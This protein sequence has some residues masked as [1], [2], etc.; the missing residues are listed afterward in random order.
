MEHRMKIVLL[1]DDPMERALFTS[2]SRRFADTIAVTTVARPEK[3][4]SLLC[5]PD[6]RPDVLLLDQRLSQ[7]TGVSVF[8]SLKQRNF[9]L[10]VC[11][12]IYS[13]G[14]DPS[15][16]ETITA[17]GIAGWIEKPVDLDAYFALLQSLRGRATLAA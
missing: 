11:T 16:L 10:P 5:D 6:T 3:L 1:D 7:H 8:A 17:L 9:P 13:E 14:V 15:L 12:Y 2:V 4:V